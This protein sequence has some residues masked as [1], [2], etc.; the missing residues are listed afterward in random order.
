[1]V[2][3]PTQV[4][5]TAA[6]IRRVA[7][8]L[9]R[10]PRRTETRFWARR[11][12]DSCSTSKSS[13]RGSSSSSRVGSSGSG[14]NSSWRVEVFFRAMNPGQLSSGNR[15]RRIQYNCFSRIEIDKIWCV[16]HRR[17]GRMKG[18]YILVLSFKFSIFR[19]RL[20]GR[21][22][23]ASLNCHRCRTLGFRTS[24]LCLH[25]PEFCLMTSHRNLHLRELRS[26]GTLHMVTAHQDALRNCFQPAAERGPVLD[27]RVIQAEGHYSERDNVPDLVR[28]HCSVPH[29]SPIDGRIEK[30][31]ST[32]Q[33]CYVAETSARAWSLSRITGPSCETLPA[34]RVRIM[35][36]S[37]AM[38][39]TASAAS[40]NEGR[41]RASRP[42][43]SAMWRARA[44]PVI[45]SMGCSLAA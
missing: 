19:Y 28:S 6:Q 16:L 11:N 2:G 26:R 32:R 1:M 8:F 24:K 40:S 13:T 18:S 37:A 42:L 23:L 9:G 36:P 29:H 43:T 27:E 33:R 17:A 31:L 39:V 5:A 12:G 45:P 30:A 10:V 44:S 41:Y 38:P 14:Y 15:Q 7:V 3:R 35:S 21:H 20:A 4:R 22:P 34:P 25:P